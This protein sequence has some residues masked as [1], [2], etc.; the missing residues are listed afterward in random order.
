MEKI[1]MVGLAIAGLLGILNAH[2]MSIADFNIDGVTDAA[3]VNLL[4]T[5]I[6]VGSNTP[7]FDLNNDGLV[8]LNDLDDWFPIY[9]VDNGGV[10][11]VSIARVD[12]NFDLSNT[13]LDLLVIQN[14]QSLVSSLFTSGDINADGVVNGLDITRYLSLGGV[15]VL[16]PAALWLFGTG[17]LGLIG[18]ARRKKVA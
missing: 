11:D 6:S 4:T 8:N 7:S 14:N 12:I 18:I 2:A 16:I 5:E 13:L 17:L 9:S 15:A 1:L 3:D 10:P